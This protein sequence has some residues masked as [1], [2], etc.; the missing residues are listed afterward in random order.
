MLCIALE[1]KLKT[2]F[3]FAMLTYGVMR[4]CTGGKFSVNCIVALIL[5]TNVV[6][7][8]R[9]LKMNCFVPPSELYDDIQHVESLR[10]RLFR[11][12]LTYEVVA[13]N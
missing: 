1:K 6:Q 12:L 13:F 3:W 4:L 2:I 11:M 5:Q 10:T 7:G 9:S 8:R